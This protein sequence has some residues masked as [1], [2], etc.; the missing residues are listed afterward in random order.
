ML[1]FLCKLC[2]TAL[3]VGGVT[4]IPAAAQTPPPQNVRASIEAETTQPAPGDV[5]TVAII[6]DPKPGWHDYWVN[7]GDAGTPLELEW[8]L[9]SG[10]T[11]GAIRAPVPETLIVSGFMNHIYKRKHAFLVD[12]RIPA[13]AQ[14]GQTLAMQVDARWSAC[15]DLVCVPESAILSVPM[16][17]GSGRISQSNRTRFDA[18]RSALPVPLDR[19]ATYAIDGTRISIAIPYP[20]SA[21]AGRI[22]FFAQ[23]DGLFRYAAPQSARRTGD[24][25]IVSGEVKK[26]F[27]GDIS[28]LLRFNDAQGLDVRAM[29]GTV[30]EGGDAVSVLGKGTAADEQ[31]ETM[32]FGWI[33]LFSIA[34]GLL[35]NLMPCVFPILGLK[36]LSLAKMGGD[37]AEARRDAVAY[38]FGIILSCLVLGGI[39]LGLR[40]AGEEV[41]W[42]FQLQ[43]PAVVLILFLLMVAVTANLLGMFEVGGIGAGENLTR[44]GGLSGSFWTGVLAAVVATPCTGP[45]MAAAMGAALLLPTGL[46]LL[47]FAGLGLGLAL[48]FLAIAF[49]PPLRTRMP[50]PGPWMVRFRHWMALPMALTSLALLWLIYQ[51]AGFTGLLVGSAAALIILVRLFEL[52]RKQKNGSPYK[53]V[54]IALFGIA[55][56]AALIIGRVTIEPR[57]TASKE[58]SIAFS[59]ARL[60]ALRAEGKPVF[61][62]FTADWCV[63]C[64]VN[65]GAAIDRAETKRAFERAGIVTMV[66]DYTRRDPD[67]T[68][69]LAK[70]GRSGVPLY[71]YFPEKGAAKILPQILTVSD[72]TGLAE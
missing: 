31:T 23:N 6:M 47:I 53:W 57:D 48:P 54:V 16:T 40:A 19:T 4:V 39:M 50:R 71:I 10:V 9:P 12:L 15:S 20:R 32:G 25:L 56:A 60:N 14:R 68:R 36:A 29:P 61:L 35:L 1:Q 33:L 43:D 18:W 13:N 51:L 46:A 62:Y 37:E 5:V 7:P 64:K 66:G 44:Q 34:G 11:A 38:S 41:G 42:A 21:S 55:I 69:Y 22:W 59:E 63:T 24:W 28:G 8:T 52:G 2:L 70:Y 27:D 45:F 72:L 3:L 17:I 26:P 49:I 30:P 58:G 65:E 67:I